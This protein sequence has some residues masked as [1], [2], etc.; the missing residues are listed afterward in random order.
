[1][2][3]LMGQN[4]ANLAVYGQGGVMFF[5]EGATRLYVELRVAQNLL[6]VTFGGDIPPDVYDP[7]TGTYL[8]GAAPE[9]KSFYPTEFSL[10][11]GMGF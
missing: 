8:P 10:N 3:R 6:P 4:I 1:M 2:P 5:R 7:G 11:I 9:K